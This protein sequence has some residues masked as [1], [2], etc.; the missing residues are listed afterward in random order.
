MREP[1]K[2]QDFPRRLLKWA[3]LGV[4]VGGLWARGAEDGEYKLAVWVVY[5]LLARYWD[6]YN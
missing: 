3:N 1:Q 5:Q 6:P 2:A 4:G